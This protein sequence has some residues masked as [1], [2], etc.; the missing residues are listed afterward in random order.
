MTKPQT[1]KYQ[2]ALEFAEKKHKGQFRK[3]GKEYITHPIAVSDI[4]KS[5]GYGTDYQICA[6][7]HDLLEDTDADEFEIE[8]L[9]SAEVLNA[10]KLVTKRKGY[11]MAEYIAGIRADKMAF[12][13]KAADRLHNLISAKDTNEK[14]KLK[15]LLETIDWYLDFS[16]EIVAAAKDLAKTLKTPINSLPPEYTKIKELLK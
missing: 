10:V 15:Y 13:I 16:P 5:W 11:V 1:D 3:G 14:F 9:S 2:N 6:L 8:A 4:V 7:F 12:T